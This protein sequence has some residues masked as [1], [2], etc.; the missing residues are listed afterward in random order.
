[1]T[2]LIL[3]SCLGAAASAAG[4]CCPMTRRALLVVHTN[5]F[6]IELFHAGLTL[7]D[8]QDF[9]QSF[10]FR[11]PIHRA[12]RYC[13]L[14][15]C[16]TGSDC[17]Q[18]R[19]HTLLNPPRLRPL[20]GDSCKME[21]RPQTTLQPDGWNDFP[22]ES[23]TITGLFTSGGAAAC[24]TSTRQLRKRRR[25]VKP[26][27]IAHRRMSCFWAGTWSATIARFTSDRPHLRC[28]W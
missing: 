21:G 12:A 22:H 19:P 24:S 27:C 4:R 2:G 9:S 11:F 13:P 8:S 17:W 7:R 20:G 28:R 16:R 14:S 23:K 6:F 18:G 26:S 10:I 25:A 3:G 1:M 5:T 15:G